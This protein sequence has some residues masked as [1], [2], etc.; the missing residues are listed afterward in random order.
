MCYGVSCFCLQFL[1]LR[2]GAEC[3]VVGLFLT[4]HSWGGDF[5]RW[6]FLS[7]FL[8]S[9]SFTSHNKVSQCFWDF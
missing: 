1:V 4:F 9:D 5:K 8:E 2:G 6:I 7:D 3:D